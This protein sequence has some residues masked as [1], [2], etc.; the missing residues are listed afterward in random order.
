MGEG[1]GR[2][3][4][5]GCAFAAALIAAGP[6]HAATG[7]VRIE[8]LSNRADLVSGGDAL[9]QIARPANARVTADVNG[10]DVTSAFSTSGSGRLVG[11]VR[12]L[13]RR[14]QHAD[15]QACRRP[16]RAH[17]DHEP[18]DRR[19]GLRRARRSSRGCATP[20]R[21]RPTAAPARPSSRSASGRRATPSATRRSGGQLRLQARRD[22]A[23]RGLRPGQPARRRDDRHDDHRP[24]PD[25]AATSCARSSA[26]RT[27]ASTRSRCS[28]TPAAGTTSCSPTS[29]PP[30]L[31]TTCSR[32]RRPCSTTWRSRAGS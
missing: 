13:R 18:P 14:R 1:R 16:G 7:D 10:R 20:S 25:P 4:A 9:V 19:A 26:S 5:L 3:V 2:L 11:L 12:G 24:G 23:V 17:H 21:R 30:P 29:A 15:R 31:P 6:A 28:P 32:S 27:A 8:V 22:G